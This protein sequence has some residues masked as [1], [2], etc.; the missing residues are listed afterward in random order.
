LTASETSPT[1]SAPSPW[2]HPPFAVIAV[3][4]ALVISLAGAA[5]AAYL[6]YENV[7]GEAG[8]CVIAHGC[9]TVQN[10][11]YGSIG[12][13]PVSVPGLALYL[14]LA[15]LA[16]LWL[17]NSLLGRANLAALAVYGS[18]FGV[19]F[20]MYLTYIE[21]FVLDAWCIYCIVSA[22]LVSALFLIWGGLLAAGMR[23]ARSQ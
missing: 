1:D 12:G 5:L 20:S 17:R 19:L 21:A 7:R 14:A 6:V 16:A 11:R 10:S 2:T 3:A 22:I 9:S 8:V 4:F 15:L 23:R 18:L 13:V